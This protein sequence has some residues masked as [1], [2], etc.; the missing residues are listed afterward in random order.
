MFQVN[1]EVV[2]KR[3]TIKV[4]GK[5]RDMRSR[6]WADNPLTCYAVISSRVGVGQSSEPKR[7][8]EEKKNRMISLE[9][10]KLVL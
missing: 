7:V 4:N 9:K 1:E 2:L 10:E 6:S 8:L 5:Q 3:L